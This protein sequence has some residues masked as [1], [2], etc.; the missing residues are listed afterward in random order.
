[1]ATGYIFRRLIQ[2]I[3]T[4]IGITLITFVLVRLTG[5]PAAILLPPDTPQETIDA[6]RVEYG[7]DKP[8][9]I[10]YLVFVGK[11]LQGDFGTSIR[12][13]VPVIKLFAE[14][15][16][17]SMELAGVSM[18]LSILIGI[19]VGMV[20]ATRHNTWVDNFLRFW[21]F[22]F[23]AIPGFYLGLMLILLVAI[24][25]KQIPTGGRETWRHLI[26][27]SFALAS[28]L[29]AV[30]ARFTRGAVLDVLNQDY[31]R[32][33]R[34]KG[35][36]EGRVQWVHVLKNAMIPILTIIGLRFGALLSGAV[37]TETVFAW[38]G[39]GRLMVQAIATRDFPVIQV[40]VLSVALVFVFLNLAVDLAYSWLD[41]RIRYG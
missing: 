1:M 17:A 24:P 30:F 35:L 2:V 3:P 41:P 19:P 27:P 31:V 12:Y 34:A 16:P 25:I 6:F 23:Q 8:I 40:T 7:L 14:R 21:M 13:R 18:V 39:I 26:L 11:A 33:A 5:D 4:L 20:S 10:Q 38:P 22:L 9:H 15:I 28:Y 37:V 36:R 29:V 32:T